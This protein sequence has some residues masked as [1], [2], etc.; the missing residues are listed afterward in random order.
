M[1]LLDDLGDGPAPE[2]QPR[3]VGPDDP[4]AIYYTSGSTGR[5]KDV[6]RSHRTTLHRM[7]LLSTSDH[8]APTDR[9][10]VLTHCG[11]ASSE[12]DIFGALLRGAAVC[13][14]DI[15]SRGLGT[16]RLWLEQEGITL[17]HP[18]V[19]LFRRFLATLEGENLF[20]AV[21]TV[22]LG[23]EV[24]LPSD[25]EKWKRHFCRGCVLLHRFSSTETGVLAVARVDYDTPIDPDVVD[26]GHPVADKQLELVDANGTP[27]SAGE[28]GD[29][30]VSSRYLAAGFWRKPAETAAAFRDDPRTPGQR[31]YRT[32]DRGRFL[33]DGRFVF[34]GRQDHQVKIRGYRV[35]IR[36]V[37]SVLSGIEG[38][39]EAAI[40]ALKEGGEQQLH[41]FVVVNSNLTA[42]ASV[43]RG[44]LR[45]SLPQWKIPARFRFVDVLP[46][47]LTGK[48]A[49]Q[50]LLDE[51]RRSLAE[52]ES[53][54]EP[55]IAESPDPIERQ[56]AAAY[57][58]VLRRPLVE[59][60]V[61]FFDLGGDSLQ[62]AELHLLLEAE[63]GRS[64]SLDELLQ[65]T[66][67]AGVATL[68]RRQGF[69]PSA[70]AQSASLL[71]PLRR[72]GRGRALFLVHGARGRAV[73]RPHLLEILGRE[74][75]LYGFRARGLDG[76]ELPHGRIAE[77]A[78]DYV[79]LMRQVHPE[80]PYTLGSICAG[81][82]VALEMA[83]RLRLAGQTLAPILLIDPP[84]APRMRG[85]VTYFCKRAT[86][87]AAVLLMRV[88]VA[89]S[90]ML[91][92]LVR[93]RHFS[94][95]NKERV[96][97]QFRKS[98]Y[99]HRLAPYGG[100]VYVIGCHDR[101]RHFHAGEWNRYLTGSMQIC[102]VAT[103]HQ[104]VF[105][106]SNEHVGQYLRKYV[107]AVREFTESYRLAQSAS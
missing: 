26:A 100:P 48:V 34:L 85:P 94:S 44:R 49:R 24:V 14:F 2:D 39:S 95:V 45:G 86:L 57:A 93:R 20:P 54:A 58:R 59:R 92:L 16:F 102:N 43:L 53:Q 71:I 74:Q 51:A 78:A 56:V 4:C 21:R 60:Q 42:D 55:P 91:E 73:A 105:D 68:A 9:Q 30:V 40:V 41:A 17:L 82:L 1:L 83:R 72:S 65:N 62:F 77:M 18:P 80:G 35:D 27:V 15:A 98:S 37:E 32:G 19:L 3:V 28:V 103:G 101:L 89:G 106:P 5:P 66:T 8:P 75:P 36:E 22:A 97:L 13:T 47:T 90:A 25:L 67:V 6:V 104:G 79:A 7:W 10:T 70:P 69:A 31:T 12:A 96:W 50:Q 99:E 81:A 76:A 107:E 46:T 87:S 61:D 23:G 88:P 33:A 38:V 11:F 52:C 29:V 63:L 64:F 84:L